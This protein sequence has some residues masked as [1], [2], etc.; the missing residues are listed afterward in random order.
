MSDTARILIID[1]DRAFR[2]GT[3]ALLSDEGY[4]VDAAP[5]GDPGLEMLRSDD[6]DM[7]LLDLKMEGRTGLSVLEEIRRSGNDI[8]VL[9]LTG[10]ATVD[11]AVQALKLGA[12]DYLTKPCDNDLLRAKIR[13]IIARREPVLGEGAARIVGNG[14]KMREVLRMVARVAPTESTVLLRG[15]TGTGKELV[16]RA[17]HEESARQG[18]AFVAVNCSALAEGLLES[19]LFGHARGAFTG[20]VSDRKGL[21]EEASGGTIFLDEI[22]DVSPA[23]Q[24]RLLRVLQERE[25]TRVGTARSVPVDVRVIAA[26]HQD[27]EARVE[28]GKFRADLYFRLKVFQIRIPELRERPEDVP[29]LAAAAVARWNERVSSPT[30]KVTGLSEEAVE[31]LRRYDWPGNVRE[32][33]AAIEHACIVC[34]GGRILPHHLPEEIREGAGGE[35]KV[36]MEE[37]SAAEAGRRY[38]A[39]DPEA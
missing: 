36:E 30:R 27:L 29:A 26:T 13:A 28:E 25:V 35:R 31:L 16:A 11:S 20:A 1:D 15:A 39:P 24:A 9:M 6:Y 7:V 12:D 17:I 18:K 23:M 21:F 32:L 38:Q 2:V 10:F 19:E 33:L 22:G 8:P 3:G 37:R 34:E 4:V 14:P 5:G